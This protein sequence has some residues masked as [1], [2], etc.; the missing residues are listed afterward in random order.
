MQ[1]EISLSATATDSYVATDLGYLLHKNPTR[2]FTRKVSSGTATVFYSE[3]NDTNCTAILHVDVDPIALVRGKN[4][5][6]TGLLDQYVNTRPFV[7]NSILSVAIN[8]SFAQ[9]MAGKSKDRQ[10]LAEQA[11][12]FKIVL[13]PVACQEGEAFIASLFEPLGYTCTLTPIGGSSVDKLY[14]ISLAAT[15][16]LSKLLNQ[17]YVLIPVLDNSK[18]W[19]VDETEVDNLINKGANWLALHPLREIITRRSLK[20][21]KEL[22][23]VLL[24]RLSVEEDIK[25]IR[26]S[27]DTIFTEVLEES[28]SSNTDTNAKPVRLHEQR[29]DRVAQLL[30]AHSVSRVLD[31]GC[32]EGKL[33]SRLLKTQQFKKILGV[34]PSLR[35]LRRARERF[36]LEDGGEALNERLQF[37]LGSLTYADRRLRGFDA[38]TLVEVIE[39][40]DPNRLIAL[41]RSLFGDARPSLIIVTTP[42]AD[43]N[44]MFETLSAGE[45]RHDDHRFEWTRAEFQHWCQRVA[46]EYGYQ[47]SIEPL[48]PEDEKHGAISQLASFT[49]NTSRKQT[50]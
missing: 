6:T 40:I 50:A 14:S 17:L 20:H 24:S 47:E 13:G 36:Y 15:V 33:I 48:G 49:I 2:V 42:N 10:A 4:H 18:H 35:S 7:A 43:Y 38:A 16:L 25:E 19:W 22:E 29:L 5:Q 30:Q 27:N 21:R 41:E 31:L 9:S 28:S 26:V 3:S 11:L 8:K 32:G 45:Y 34:D 44:A 23:N 12:P 1:L 46:L 37:Q 39:H